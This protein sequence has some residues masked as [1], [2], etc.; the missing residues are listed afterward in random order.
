MNALERA[1]VD[2]DIKPLADLI[3]YLVDAN[4]KGKPIAKI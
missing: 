2:Q 1:S 3:A 4:L